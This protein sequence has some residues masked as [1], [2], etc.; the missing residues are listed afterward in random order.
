[1]GG[2]QQPV[3]SVEAARERML[4]AV[5]P[6]GSESVPLHAA[7]RRTLAESLLAT[8]SQPPFRSSAMDGYAVRSADLPLKRLRVAG[9]AA[10][11]RAYPGSLEQGQ[12]VRIFTGAPLP[13]GADADRRSRCRG[14]YVHRRSGESKAKTATRRF[15]RRLPAHPQAHRFMPGTLRWCGDRPRCSNVRRAPR[16]GLSRPEAKS[17]P[18]HCGWSGSNIR[19]GDLGPARIDGWAELACA[20]APGRCRGGIARARRYRRCGPAVI[21]GGASVALRYR[22]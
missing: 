3:L 17:P 16:I 19:F 8:R 10:A 13:R 18:W 22:E 21:V 12:A 5:R 20:M 7:L 4:S 6:L 11:G 14:H 2:A 9:E 1:M 15:C